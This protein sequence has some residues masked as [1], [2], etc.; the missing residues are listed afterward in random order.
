M[1]IPIP[2][3][4][5]QVDAWAVGGS[6]P[7]GTYVC[8]ISEVKEGQSSGGHPQI[9]L[10]L[11]CEDGEQRGQTQRDWITV[12]PN[13][14]GKVRQVLEAANVQLP[15]GPFQLDS[16]MLANKLV[17]IVVREERDN[18][19]KP[20]NRV[21]GYKPATQAGSAGAVQPPAQAAG[22]PDDDLPF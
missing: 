3:D 16:S 12:T 18:E 2:Q 6:L 17:E 13:T 5:N 19:G 22:V 21:Q 9:E 7:P 8:R 10:E 11:T 4:L 15:A 1:A 14:L 20:R